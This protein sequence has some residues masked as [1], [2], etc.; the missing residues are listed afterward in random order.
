MSEALVNRLTRITPLLADVLDFERVRDHLIRNEVL[1]WTQHE[2]LMAERVK[3][4]RN[5]QLIDS[6]QHGSLR[7][8]LC[9]TKAMNDAKYKDL[10]RYVLKGKCKLL[11][12]TVYV[13]VKAMSANK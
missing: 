10:G 9:A 13:Q 12:V 7:S 5:V 4:D 3:Y 6:L 11:K 8:L 1:N 2:N